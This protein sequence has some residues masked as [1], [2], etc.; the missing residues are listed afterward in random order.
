MPDFPVALRL[1]G[2]RVVLVG[3]SDEACIKAERLRNTGAAVSVIATQL[4]D[5]MRTLVDAGGVVYHARPWTKADFVDARF[6]IFAERD[7]E[8]ARAMRADAHH[9][10]ALFSALDDPD[11]SDVSHVAIV[12]AGPVQIALMSGGGA[13]ALIRRIR[14]TLEESLPPAF[15]EFASRV[16]QKRAAIRHLPRPEQK[17]MLEG[18][19]KGFSMRVALHLPPWFENENN[20]TE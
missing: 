19:L 11:N 6:V 3:G 2:A 9:A 18:W 8:V 12:D 15:A 20:R 14:E 13:P 10:G 4:S 16:V 7:A 17:V 1:N 5:R